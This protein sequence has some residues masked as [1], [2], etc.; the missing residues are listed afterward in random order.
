[1]ASYAYDEETANEARGVSAF[2]GH[3]PDAGRGDG[4][5]I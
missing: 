1:M 2:G 3:L 4:S 5:S